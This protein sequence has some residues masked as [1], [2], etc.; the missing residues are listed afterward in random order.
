LAGTFSRRFRLRRGQAAER[1]AERFLRRR[2]LELVARNYRTRVGELDL[3][4]LERD[5][6]VVIEVRFRSDNR[7]VEPALTV[8]EPKQARI[9]QATRSLLAEQAWLAEFAIR[10]DVVAIGN[11]QARPGAI[12]WIRDAFRV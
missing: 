4:M 12:Q 9:I 1:R 6:L 5:C 8:N 11:T 2:G 3:V 7:F 10:F